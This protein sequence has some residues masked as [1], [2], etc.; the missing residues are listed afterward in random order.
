MGLLVSEMLEIL[1]LHKNSE[2]KNISICMIGKQDL[3]IEWES[4]F[5]IC[6]K[7]GIT[8]NKDLYEEVKDKCPIDSFDF[9]N[10]F[11]YG[12]VH[13]LDYSPYEGAD[14]IFDLNSP[15][16]PENIKNRFDLVINGGTIEH[17]F[18]ISYA[19]KSL[20]EITKAGGYIF[21]LS[22]LSG[23]IDHGFFSISPTFFFDYYYGNHFEIEKIVFEFKTHN[24]P[25]MGD[26][27]YS[28]DYRL[29]INQFDLSRYVESVAGGADKEVMLQCVARKKEDSTA[30]IIPIQGMYQSIYSKDENFV[31]DYE[32]VVHEHILDSEKDGIMLYGTG[33]NCNSL[34]SAI[35][36]ADCDDKIFGIFNSNA[37]KCGD[38]FRGYRIV[39]PTKEKVFASKKIII[40]TSKYEN[41]VVDFLLGMGYDKEKIVRITD[42][43]R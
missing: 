22:P 16:V 3:L 40:S 39:Y 24:G 15:S 12:E 37:D 35:F 18:H 27:V 38:L 5:K 32:S 13:A 20:S 31:I 1:K 11:G 36:K 25:Q 43:K 30:G 41:E 8:Y 29:F 34:I 14:I 9:F 21:N 33:D 19:I 23:W 6:E 10:V 7:Y 28:Q 2:R 4:F 42:Y 17:V 26:V